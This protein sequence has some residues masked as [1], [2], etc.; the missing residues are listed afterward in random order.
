MNPSPQRRV[1]QGGLASAQIG[2]QGAAGG[3]CALKHQ[4]GQGGTWGDA[5]IVRE[6]Q[7]LADDVHAGS[8]VGV[9]EGVHAQGGDSL[10]IFLSEKKQTWPD[11]FLFTSIH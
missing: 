1:Q 3:F 11:D 8:G 2:V 10:F 6:R 7:D 5:P 4:R 9:D